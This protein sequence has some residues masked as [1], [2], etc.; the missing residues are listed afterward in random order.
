MVLLVSDTSKDVLAFESDGDFHLVP[1]SFETLASPLEELIVHY[2]PSQFTVE[3]Y[4]N[5]VE[6]GPTGRDHRGQSCACSPQLAGG[7]RSLRA[8]RGFK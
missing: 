3:E 8:Y 6:T 5:L 7:K 1:I 4:P 2:A